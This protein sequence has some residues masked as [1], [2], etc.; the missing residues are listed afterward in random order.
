M[1]AISV[2]LYVVP[3]APSRADRLDHAEPHPTWRVVTVSRNVLCYLIVANDIGG[4]AMAAA[5]LAIWSTNAALLARGQRSTAPSGSKLVDRGEPLLT[6]GIRRC[7]SGHRY[8]HVPL[9]IDLIQ[10]Q[11]GR[12]CRYMKRKGGPR[13]SHLVYRFAEAEQH[14]DRYV[15]RRR[16]TPQRS[17]L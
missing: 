5:G 3:P 14:G 4:I 1:R 15:A 7:A 6:D 12:T 9:A 10:L 8:C 11:T 17:G 13:R 2:P 16:E